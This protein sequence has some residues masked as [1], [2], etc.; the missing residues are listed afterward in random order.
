[1]D[2]NSLSHTTWERKYHLV[3]EPKYRRQVI[4]G[5]IKTDVAEILSIQ[6]VHK[7]RFV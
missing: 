7:R 3:F 2:K 4:Y 5:Q 1:M 6:R